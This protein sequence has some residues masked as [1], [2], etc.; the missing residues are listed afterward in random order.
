MSLLSLITGGGSGVQIGGMTLDA[1]LVETHQF[2]AAVTDYEVEDGSVITDHIHLKPVTLLIEGVVSDSPVSLV[3]S[4]VGSAAT[5]VSGSIGRNFG[6]EAFRNEG[7]AEQALAAGAGS[8]AGLVTNVVADFGFGN[9][10]FKT[11]NDAFDYMTGLHEARSPVEI[12]TSLRT[13]KNMVIETLS[14]PRTPET[15]SSSIRFSVSLKQITVVSSAVVKL[16]AF[17]V[18]SDAAGASSQGNLGSQATKPASESDAEDGSLLFQSSGRP[19]AEGI[20]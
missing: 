20:L 18:A 12:V 1:T 5:L 13:Y 2:T 14:V 19:R 7:L 3:A 4:A 11:P 17:K 16:P 10:I 9:T 15:G 6:K 8:I